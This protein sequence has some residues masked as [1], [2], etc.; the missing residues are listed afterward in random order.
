MSYTNL[1]SIPKV[2]WNVFK[3]ITT[4]GLHLCF[5]S[6]HSSEEDLVYCQQMGLVAANFKEVKCLNLNWIEAQSQL[7]LNHQNRRDIVIIEDG[8]EVSRIPNPNYQNMLLIFRYLQFLSTQKISQIMVEHSGKHN[9]PQN[10]EQHSTSTASLKS[11][12]SVKKRVYR[13]RSGN[14][15]RNSRAKNS[16]SLTLI[17]PKILPKSDVGKSIELVTRYPSL[18][19][20]LLT[21]ETCSTPNSTSFTYPI[22][23]DK[24]RKRPYQRKIKSKSAEIDLSASGSNSKP[25]K[26]DDVSSISK[27]AEEINLKKNM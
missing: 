19:N 22:I 17:A 24:R 18:S 13:S 11:N 15:S 26:I 2:S 20:L 3:K 12:S 5:Y 8:K 25:Q 21:N 4:K 6:I 10:K 1:N 14:N 9:I 27:N 7:K 23:L 16:K